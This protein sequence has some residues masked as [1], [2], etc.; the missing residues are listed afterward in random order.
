[1]PTPS[2][3]VLPKPRSEDEFE[4]IAVDCLRIRWRDPNALRNG[5]R[6]QSQHG[7]DIVGH[8]PWLNGRTAGGQCK[9]T[10][11]LSL[12]E[13]TR[14]VEKAK[15]FPGGLGEFYLVT[16]SDRDAKLQAAVR[17]YVA[18][19]APPFVVVLVFWEDVVNEIAN[20]SDLVAK[21]WKGFF[22]QSATPEAVS[23]GD[24]AYDQ[25]TR[26]A[27]AQHQRAAPIPSG[28]R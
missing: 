13:V 10:D 27:E 21:H 8:P 12:S 15:T 25:E 5:R 28:A 1:M 11:S 24:S 16:S 9:K 6:G 3:A 22:G 17:E 20:D 19:N 2:T 23:N 26:I 18:T 7:V 4:D 14:E